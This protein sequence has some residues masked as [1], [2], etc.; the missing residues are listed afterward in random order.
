MTGI[1]NNDT[2]RNN[3]L[4]VLDLKSYDQLNKAKFAESM[5]LQHDLVKKLISGTTK[6][7]GIK[8]IVT[9][10]HKLGCSIDELVGHKPKNNST[11]N[12]I[13]KNL[14]FNKI[15][16]ESTLTYILDYIHNN[17]LKPNMGKILHVFDNIYDYSFRKN[18]N[19]PDT[20]F[21]DWIMNY[22]LKD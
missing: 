16:F 5:G 14:E 12:I 11:T 9:I 22:M 20:T 21:A 17:Q 18:L 19:Q 13:S 6:N 8:T 10:A 15:L 4:N 7:P 2:L 1:Y 3:L